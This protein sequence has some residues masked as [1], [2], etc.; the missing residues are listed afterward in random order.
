[1]KKCACHSEKTHF[2]PRGTIYGF[3]KLFFTYPQ[4]PLVS[5]RGTVQFFQQ[6]EKLFKSFLN[7]TQKCVTAER[8][9]DF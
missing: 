4:Y 5:L 8:I 6:H 2:S 1:M 9:T 3:H 7:D